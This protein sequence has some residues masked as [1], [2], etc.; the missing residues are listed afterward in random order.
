MKSP[1]VVKRK[2]SIINGLDIN[3]KCNK[4]RLKRRQI[5]NMYI[6]RVHINI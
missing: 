1:G 5:R 3:V 4:N 6:R 2:Y